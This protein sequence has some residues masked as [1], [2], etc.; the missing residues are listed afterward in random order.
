M[1]RQSPSRFLL[2]SL[3]LL[4]RGRALDVAAGSGRNTI[5]LAEHGFTVHALDRN[6]EALEEA[7]HTARDPHLLHVTTEIVDL[8]GEPFPH[9][10]FPPATYDVVIVFFYLFRPAFPALARTLKPGGMLVYETFLID[11]YR[12][13]QRPRHQEFCL[14]HG[15]L[16]TLVPGLEVVHCNE[17]AR[18]GKGEQG[19]TYTARLLVRKKD[20]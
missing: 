17:G 4:P 16:R 6:P 14:A 15:E 18:E 7:R 20:G 9:H 12:K 2:E 8:E 11:N 19:E 5:V 10:A 3:P 1:P 13:Y